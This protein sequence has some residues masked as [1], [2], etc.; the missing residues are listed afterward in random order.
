MRWKREKSS[1]GLSISRVLPLSWLSKLKQ[2]SGK[3]H[4][5]PAKKTK[6]KSPSSSTVPA[7]FRSSPLSNSLSPKIL[8]NRR[9]DSNQIRYED[10]EHAFWS[11]SFRK[12]N[13]DCKKNG[14]CS[15]DELE[16]EFS[17]SENGRSNRRNARNELNQ[18]FLESQ[19]FKNM[20]LGISKRRNSTAKF[21]ILQKNQQT[22]SSKE[23]KGANR[24][25]RRAVGR[26]EEEHQISRRKP[27]REDQR[28][29]KG[30]Q[31]VLD[32]IPVKTERKSYKI[33]DYHLRIVS[34][35]SRSSDRMIPEVNHK[36][37]GKDSRNPDRCSILTNSE[38]KIEKDPM[39]ENLLSRSKRASRVSR[40]LQLRKTRQNTKGGMHSPR[41]ASRIEI[42]K[43]K[44]LEKLKKKTKEKEIEKWRGFDSLAVMKRS[45]NPQKDF[46]DSMVEMIEENKIGRPEELERLLACYLTLNSEEYH[47]MIVKEFR[48][49]WFDLN[50]DCFL[51]EI[52]GDKYNN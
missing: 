5:E 40:D 29:I 46:R 38:Q 37:S 35:K 24:K 18:E 36:I 27:V 6:S 39:I 25:S 45:F 15:E 32:L 10:P 26:I 44:A 8:L 33:Q 42:C 11:F 7:C 12:N 43:I 20:L 19:K 22:I 48:Q 23:P 2:M 47:D 50:R 51:S 52:E 9:T 13:F 31:R 17:N 16:F 4:S 1:P 28:C 3:N 49:V 21:D 14:A 41:T 30:D 34:P